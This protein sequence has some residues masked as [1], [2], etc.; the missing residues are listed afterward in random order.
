MHEEVHAHDGVDEHDEHEQQPDV[1]EGWQGDGER[2]EQS[3]DAFRRLDQTQDTAHAE[4][5]Y[6][7]QQGG[8]DEE[9]VLELRQ[10]RGCNTGPEQKIVTLYIRD[11]K[12]H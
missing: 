12:V 4:H 10:G 1:E 6:H 7:T 9:A 11:R 3:P 5:S 8:R 2:E